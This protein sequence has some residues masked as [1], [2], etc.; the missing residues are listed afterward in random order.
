MTLRKWAVWEENEPYVLQHLL[1]GTAEPHR[2]RL[3]NA[4]K[5]SGRGKMHCPAWKAFSSKQQRRKGLL[6]V[7]A[8]GWSLSCSGP[9]AA[10]HHQ[11]GCRMGKGRERRLE[12]MIWGSL[13]HKTLVFTTHA[14][15]VQVSGDVCS[16]LWPVLNSGTAKALTGLPWVSSAGGAALTW[17][18]DNEELRLRFQEAVEI[19]DGCWHVLHIIEHLEKVEMLRAYSVILVTIITG[20]T[21]KRN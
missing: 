13:A 18:Q 11:T 6:W 10:I 4:T 12:P 8:A 3:L 16:P 1:Y 9:P 2:G 19:P 21:V 20:T 5:V 15:T 17:H 14:D 7:R